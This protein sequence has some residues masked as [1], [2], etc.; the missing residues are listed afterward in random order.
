MDKSQAVQILVNVAVQS[1]K[2]MEGE[3]GAIQEAINAFKVKPEPVEEP[4]KD[5]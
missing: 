5:K 1:L 3:A 4:K 2:A